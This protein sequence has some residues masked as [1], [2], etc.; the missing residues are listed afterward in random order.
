MNSC[1]VAS[2][3]LTTNGH[4]R[5]VADRSSAISVSSLTG[6]SSLP[7]PALAWL[8]TELA[9]TISVGMLLGI[10]AVVGRVALGDCS[11]PES[12]VAVV[13]GA[14]EVVGA[15]GALV[16]EAT[17][18]QVCEGVYASSKLAVELAQLSVDDGCQSDVDAEA[19]SQVLDDESVKVIT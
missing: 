1:D 7:V 6:S 10:E 2:E 5:S 14:Y 12:C 17:I 9:G 13:V 3:D 4:G 8:M 11:S 19:L 18:S 16:V 15:K